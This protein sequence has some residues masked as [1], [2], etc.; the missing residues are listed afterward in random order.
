V[1]IAVAVIGTSTSRRR[2]WV[3][4]HPVLTVMAVTVTANHFYLDGIVAVAI[5]LMAMRLER[6][7]RVW[8]AVRRPTEPAAV[9]EPVAA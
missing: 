8:V 7:V 4:V 5:M 9:L 6:A 1:L 3:L 2:W